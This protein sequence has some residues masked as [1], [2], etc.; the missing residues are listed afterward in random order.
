MPY[1][2]SRYSIENFGTSEQMD[3]EIAGCLDM[4]QVQKM[5]PILDVKK[6]SVFVF[7]GSRIGILKTNVS[8]TQQ[9]FFATVKYLK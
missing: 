4:N 6:M 9:L 1:K 2:R 7:F 8:I 5:A 3:S